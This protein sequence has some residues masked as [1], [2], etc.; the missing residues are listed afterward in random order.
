MDQIT[1]M[2]KKIKV[3]YDRKKELS[4]FKAYLE[5]LK[6][7]VPK[8]ILIVAPRRM[9][10]THLIQKYMLNS[11]DEK[12]VP[13]YIDLLFI[14]SIKTLS[15]NMYDQFIE[16]YST[17]HKKSLTKLMSLIKGN[18]NDL[19]DAIKEVSLEFGTK[20][21]DY[22]A[23]RFN[24]KKEVSEIEYF[25]KTIDIIEEIAEKKKL[26]VILA[27]DEFQRV[28]DWKNWNEFV[29][30]LRSN[31][32]YS[33]NTKL[34]ISGSKSTFIKENIIA[35]TKP[36]W[37]QLIS[38]ELMPFSKEVIKEI[39]RD[40]NLDER[41]VSNFESDLYN[42]PDY[43]VKLISILQTTK[44]YDDALT[45]LIDQE[46]YVF[47]SI[48][49]KLNLKSRAILK[50][51]T[52]SGKQFSDIEKEVSK[53]TYGL[54]KLLEDDIILLKN[55]KYEISDPLFRKILTNKT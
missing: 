12:I 5:E 4:E 42:I 35:K 19:L 55:N 3:F 14:D 31:M 49:D 53:P 24:L 30:A 16:N 48:Y 2:K 10:K 11:T 29:A 26:K 32:Q 38:Y 28:I 13:I 51:L 34:I 33:E 15:H 22:L 39:L 25:I 44:S 20:N 37:K 8:H 46:K 45:K 17:V 36:F 1:K 23:L 9:G 27:M 21:E 6:R 54:K 52:N 7:N 18:I 47:E 40:N 43:V 50:T 41:Y